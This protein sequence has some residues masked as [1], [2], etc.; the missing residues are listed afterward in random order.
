MITLASRSPTRATL[1]KAAGVAF[2]IVS[3]PI[4]EAAAKDDLLERGGTPLSV[5][6]SLART[7]AVAVCSAGLTI[8]ADQTLEVEGVLYD[9]VGTLALARERLA[10]LSGRTHVLHTAAAIARDG[11]VVWRHLDTA[12]LTMRR[13]SDAFVDGYLRRAGAA[14]LGSVGCYQLEGEGAQ[15]FE[16]I[17]GDYFSI[18]GL[19]LIAVLAVLRREGALER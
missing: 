14:A 5:A 19:P 7:K 8:G 3:P 10:M 9:K 17:D 1:L 13:F 15:L 6:E 16:A 2:K 4:D 11:V 18:L 12:Y